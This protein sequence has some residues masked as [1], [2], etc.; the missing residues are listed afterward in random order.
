MLDLRDGPLVGTSLS[1]CVHCA[2]LFT[3]THH[4]SGLCNNS[5]HESLL[6]TNS[7][8]FTYSLIHH[9]SPSIIH[10]TMTSSTSGRPARRQDYEE[11]CYAHRAASKQRLLKCGVV[12]GARGGG[13]AGRCVCVLARCRQ[14]GLSHAHALRAFAVGT[15]RKPASGSSIHD[16]S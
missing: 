6:F 5:Q 10:L 7:P 4:Y 8:L 15:H 12:G 13:S 2:L 9:Y 3:I 16:A 14:L 1:Y 11:I